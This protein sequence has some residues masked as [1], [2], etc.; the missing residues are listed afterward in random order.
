M[1]IVQH[2]K[3]DVFAMKIPDFGGAEEEQVIFLML[4]EIE[5]LHHELCAALQ[6]NEVNKLAE[7]SSHGTQP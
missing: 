6:D 5:Q 4:S 1:F 3:E 7:E 2:V